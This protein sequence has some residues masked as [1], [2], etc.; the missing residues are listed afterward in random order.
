MQVPGQVHWY[1]V[2]DGEEVHHFQA[3]KAPGPD[4]GMTFMVFGDMGESKHH[5]AKSP[6]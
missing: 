4:S 5:R 2:G 3:A 6:G 1:S